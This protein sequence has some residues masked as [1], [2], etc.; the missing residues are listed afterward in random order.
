MYANSFNVY[1]DAE[2]YFEP[3]S[4]DYYV[5]YELN[6]PS[7][8]VQREKT[9]KIHI[10]APDDSIVQA[11]TLL[12]G[13]NW[14]GF[15]RL[16]RDGYSDTINNVAS[17]LVPELNV[18]ESQH[19]YAAFEDYWYYYGLQELNSKQGYKLRIGG[20][21]EVTFMEVGT[22]I[23]T[24]SVYSLNEGWNWITYPC[25]TTAYPE[26]ALAGVIDNVDYVRAETWSMQ[27][28]SGEWMYGF[29]RPILRYGDSIEVRAT[30]T[31]DLSWNSGQERQYVK[32]I[33]SKYY[34]FEDRSDY[35][36]LIV[37]SIEGW[38]D[39]EEIGVFQEDMCI[40]ARVLEGYP[41][42]IL[43]YSDPENLESELEFMIYTGSKVQKR[44]KV[45]N[46]VGGTKDD[47]TLY[48]EPRAFLRI[49]LIVAGDDIPTAFAIESNYPNPF[50][51]STTISFT[52]P[53]SAK[54]KLTVYNIKGQ[55]VKELIN[56]TMDQGKHT[57]LLNGKDHSDRTVSSGLYFARV[58]H[59]GKS[60][61]IKMMLM[62]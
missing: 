61:T 6:V 52:I 45:V 19:G 39:F 8:S 9:Y 3:V 18:I 59:E 48:P 47:N 7:L 60:K 37:E 49:N 16:I 13:W 23:D 33:E 46:I 57:I 34:T 54:T 26:E 44:L 10:I 56:G 5:T 43:A 30:I 15:P 58:V 51:P 29:R 35:E 24:T 14:I 42:Q 55:K 38:P 27:K 4:G 32:L 40:G 31:C 17:T 50:N 28:I 20:D 25:A 21:T 12:P 11:R 62:K 1:Y 53:S 41:I 2:P 22:L 36:T